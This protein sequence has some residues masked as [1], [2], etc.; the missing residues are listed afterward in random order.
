MSIKKMGE[1]F[2][3]LSDPGVGILSSGKEALFSGKRGWWLFA[4]FVFCLK[5]EWTLG[6]FM[7]RIQMVVKASNAA[8]VQVTSFCGEE[9]VPREVSSRKPE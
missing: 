8:T 2:W 7:L 5:T 4:V 9:F 1:S 3:A 6:R